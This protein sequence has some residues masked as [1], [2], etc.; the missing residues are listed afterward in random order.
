MRLVGLKHSVFV[1]KPYLLW[2][3]VQLFVHCKIRLMG[4]L[5]KTVLSSNIHIS[6][7]NLPPFLKVEPNPWW[8]EFTS[9]FKPI[10]QRLS[11]FPKSGFLNGFDLAPLFPKVGLDQPFSKVEWIS[12]WFRFLLHFF[13]SGFSKWF[14]FCSTFPKS[15]FGST[16]F[17]GWVDLAPP[18]L[19]VEWK[20]RT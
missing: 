2:A 19:K 3:R 13:K 5:S 17:K 16:F 4:Y 1:H 8:G 10:T 18:F 7:E 14:R 9:I 20:K 15:G 11:G 12:K 6:L